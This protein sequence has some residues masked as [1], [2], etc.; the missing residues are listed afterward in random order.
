MVACSL[1][2]G[3][4]TATDGV[5]EMQYKPR[6]LFGDVQDGRSNQQLT[7]TVRW[8]TLALFC[9]CPRRPPGPG[10]ETGRRCAGTRARQFRRCPRNG[11]RRQGSSQPLCEARE[12][13]PSTAAM[14]PFVSPE[15]GPQCSSE[16]PSRRAKR[17]CI[18]LRPPPQKRHAA[19]G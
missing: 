7:S 12:G 9:R 4:N 15:T 3:I 11:R 13:D 6:S 10:D 5:M 2:Q 19:F 1:K 8:R 18:S 16:R 17:D 14:P